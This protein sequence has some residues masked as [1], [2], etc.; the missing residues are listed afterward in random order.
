MVI[1]PISAAKQAETALSQL[2]PNERFRLTPAAPFSDPKVAFVLSAKRIGTDERF[3]CKVASKTAND[4]NMLATHMHAQQ[5]AEARMRSPNFRVPKVVHYNSDEN[6]LIQEDAKGRS[7][8][9]IL[10]AESKDRCIDAITRVGAWISTYH[11]TTA[12]PRPFDPYPYVNWLSGR[13]FGVCSNEA[14]IAHAFDV[15]DRVAKAAAGQTAIYAITH[16]DCHASQFLLRGSGTVYAIDFEFMDFDVAIRDLQRL[17]LQLVF[18]KD[19]CERLRPNEIWDILLTG[20]GPLRTARDVQLYFEIFMRLE[21]LRRFCAT[22]GQAPAPNTVRDY[23]DG[24][25]AVLNDFEP[26]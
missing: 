10:R 9:D 17:W 26:R 19:L 7:L 5:A 14:L 22:A 20:Y 16:R 2:F 25:S 11:Q 18:K 24:L 12:E 15:L 1:S 23:E 4:R 8:A 3:I 21:Q 13:D 6:C